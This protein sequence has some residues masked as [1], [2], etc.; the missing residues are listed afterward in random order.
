[1]KVNAL[2][3][4]TSPQQGLNVVITGGSKGLGR[5]LVKQFD[6]DPS[7]NKV[8][9]TSRNASKDMFYSSKVTGLVAD[10]S[11]PKGSETLEENIGNRFHGKIDIW[12]NNAASSDGNT[13]FQDIQ[14][15]QVRDIVST[16]LTGALVSTK[17]AFAIANKYNCATRTCHIFNVV[18]AGADGSPT[19]GYSVYGCTKAALLQFTKS[20][21]NELVL[22][23]RTQNVKLH[24]ISPGMMPTALLGTN[25]SPVQKIVFNIF[26][27]EP[28]VIAGEVA[29]KIIDVASKNKTNEYI[30]YLTIPRIIFHGLTFS[31]RK[32]RFYEE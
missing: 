11:S 30:R 27:E 19:P 7:V 17:T 20:I 26:C 2:N 4:S 31:F 9:F 22:H 8:L 16:N 1:M 14:V 29:P 6:R 24:I 12:I 18:G 32:G 5:A 23:S 10:V 13:L 21:Q 25:M 28:D 15:Q 3:A